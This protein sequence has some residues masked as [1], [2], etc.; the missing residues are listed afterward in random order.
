MLNL[1]RPS[2]CEVLRCVCSM[3]QIQGCDAIL[4]RMQEML[5]GFQAD[6]GGISDEIKHLQVR[7]SLMEGCTHFSHVV[8]HGSIFPTPLQVQL[9]NIWPVLMSGVCNTVGHGRAHRLTSTKTSCRC[10]FISKLPDTARQIFFEPAPRY[11]YVRFWCEH[12]VDC[13]GSHTNDSTS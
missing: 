7:R 10:D 1:L 5:L 11:V 13:S 12:E 8:Q 9:K 3:P 6:L 4:A 2:Q